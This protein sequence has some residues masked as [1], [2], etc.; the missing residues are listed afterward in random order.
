MTNHYRIL[1]AFLCLLVLSPIHAQDSDSTVV[2]NREHPLV[3]EDAWDLWPYSFLNAN[4][5]AVGY[6]IDLIKLICDVL[7]YES[8]LLIEVNL[9]DNDEVALAVA[10]LFAT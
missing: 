9:V 3:Y 7:T 2:F 1:L 10:Y 4:G 6:N 5:E 8:E